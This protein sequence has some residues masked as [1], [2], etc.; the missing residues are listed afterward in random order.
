M[1]FL[2]GAI[3]S[4]QDDPL[5]FGFYGVLVPASVLLVIN[6]PTVLWLLPAGL[7]VLINTRSSIVSQATSRTDTGLFRTREATTVLNPGDEAN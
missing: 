6:R 5:M 4:A 7:S 3:A 2:A 1:A